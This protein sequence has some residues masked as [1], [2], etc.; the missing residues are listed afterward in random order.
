MISD[1][2]NY[3]DKTLNPPKFAYKSCI[4]RISSAQ[5]VTT[6]N[7]TSGKCTCTPSPGSS[8]H[9]VTVPATVSMETPKVNK[10]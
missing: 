4:A 9:T 6:T 3:V 8:Y 2:H 5:G 1:K 7:M 10:H